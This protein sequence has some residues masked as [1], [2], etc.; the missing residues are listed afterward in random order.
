[1]TQSKS[2]DKARIIASYLRT[3]K[4]N[5][6]AARVLRANGNRVSAY[7]LEQA[8]ENILLALCASEGIHIARPKSHQLDEN[9]ERLS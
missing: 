5:V 8:A 4:E 3:A 1:M 7:T 9:V 6:A 2:F